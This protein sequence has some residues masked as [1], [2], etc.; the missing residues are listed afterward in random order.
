MEERGRWI[1]LDNG[2]HVFLRAGETIRQH[3]SGKLQKT[4]PDRF[5]HG[6][7]TQD[8]YDK[9]QEWNNGMY[10]NGL[11]KEVTYEWLLKEEQEPDVDYEDFYIDDKGIKHKNG[12]PDGNGGKYNIR[13]GWRNREENNAKM[14]SRQ[15]GG[16]VIKQVEVSQPKH[17]K[18][19]DFRNIHKNDV[20]YIDEKELQAGFSGKNTVF[21]SALNAVGQADK[22][23]IDTSARKITKNDI[24]YQTNRIF[25]DQ[26][27]LSINYVIYTIDGRNIWK[28]FKRI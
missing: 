9:L 21:N 22:V 25:S 19:A 3:F 23:M 26:R 7:I 5:K 17:V 28:I 11:F 4:V 6:K 13:V 24:M 12:E 15:I 10:N 8:S 27:T 20:I 14:I 1:T 18:L 16:K 2:S